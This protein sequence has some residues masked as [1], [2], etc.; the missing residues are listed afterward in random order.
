MLITLGWG[1][2]FEYTDQHHGNKVMPCSVINCIN[3][4]HAVPY[5]LICKMECLLDISCLPDKYTVHAKL[6]FITMA[7]TLNLKINLKLYLL[8]VKSFY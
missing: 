6:H 7:T 2:W 4:K 1:F 3:C 5:K 8:S